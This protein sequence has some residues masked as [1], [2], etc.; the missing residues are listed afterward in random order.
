MSIEKEAYDQLFL[1]NVGKVFVEHTRQ[2]LEQLAKGPITVDFFEK[3]IDDVCS[4]YTEKNSED[5]RTIVNYVGELLDQYLGDDREKVVD[6]L[7]KENPSLGD[8][9]PIELILIGR[10]KSVAQFIET[11]IKEKDTTQV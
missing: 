10:G 4:H 2:D 1:E 5:Y 3:M 9:K 6:W 11:L 7:E 8:A